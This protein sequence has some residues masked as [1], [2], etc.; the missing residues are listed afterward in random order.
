M[1]GEFSEDNYREQS[2]LSMPS[3]PP[4]CFTQQEYNLNGSDAK[5]DIYDCS[6]DHGMGLYPNVCRVSACLH[7]TEFLINSVQSVSTR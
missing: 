7:T 5:L 1:S 4:E 6:A 2:G 3:I